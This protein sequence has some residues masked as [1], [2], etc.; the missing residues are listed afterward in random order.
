VERQIFRRVALDRLASP[1]QLDQ[2]LRVTEPAGW[3]AMLALSGLLGAALLWSCFGSLAVQ[4]AGQAALVAPAG[5]ASLEALVF[6]PA[7]TAQHVQ[8]GMPVFIAPATV[9]AEA[10]GLMRGV[11]VAVGAAPLDDAELYARLVSA[12]LVSAVGEG[13]PVIGVRVALLTD[14]QAPSGYAWSL[15]PGPPAALAEGTPAEATIVVAE[16][17]PISFVLR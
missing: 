14:P 8:P 9:S 6:L 2:L 1:E 10:H 13:D 15:P 3:V 4:V 5:G 17:R 16:R 12:G 7:R 11:V